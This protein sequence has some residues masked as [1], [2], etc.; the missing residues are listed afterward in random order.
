MFFQVCL[1]HIWI[2]GKHVGTHWLAEKELCGLRDFGS[3]SV[4]NSA[5]QLNIQN[6]ELQ[7]CLED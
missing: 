5:L 3:H 2:N 6:S 7:G 1:S 4:P